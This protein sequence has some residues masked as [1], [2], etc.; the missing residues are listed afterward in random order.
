MKGLH[1]QILPR[2]VWVRFKARDQESAERGLDLARAAVPPGYEEF[3]ASIREGRRRKRPEVT[4]G[5]RRSVS[6]RLR[7]GPL[8]RRLPLAYWRHLMRFAWA[9]SHPQG[10][11]P[12]SPQTCEH[13]TASTPSAKS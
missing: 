3:Y 2:E 4:N 9:A 11:A 6:L 12:P 13:R 5:K 1:V 8:A 10:P 7:M